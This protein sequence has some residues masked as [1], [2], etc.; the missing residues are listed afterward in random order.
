MLTTASDVPWGD[1]QRPLEE[2]ASPRA[3]RVSPGS[4]QKPHRRPVASVHLVV[5]MVTPIRPPSVLTAWPAHTLVVAKQVVW[6]AWPGRS[7]AMETLRH[8]AQHAFLVN[9]GRL[10]VL[11]T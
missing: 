2:Q 1:L 11:S 9:I 4:T 10:Q 8:L 7:T 5:P 3:S 6:S